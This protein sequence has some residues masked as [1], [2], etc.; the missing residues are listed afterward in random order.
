MVLE[1]IAEISSEHRADNSKPAGMLESDLILIE[2]VPAVAKFS[3][4]SIVT[5]CITA[6]PL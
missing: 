3:N 5:F 2:R 6:L 4:S 1:G